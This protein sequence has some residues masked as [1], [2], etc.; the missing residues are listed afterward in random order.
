MELPRSMIATLPLVS[1]AQYVDGELGLVARIQHRGLA[2]S[3][4]SRSC[5]A[6]VDKQLESRNMSP[7]PESAALPPPFWPAL[8]P[9]LLMT[10]LPLSGALLPHAPARAA[11]DTAHQIPLPIELIDTEQGTTDDSAAR[12]YP[13]HHDSVAPLRPAHVPSALLEMLT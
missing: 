1:D 10:A 3:D 8:P 13:L 9:A 2:R 7:W 4:G 5:L 12:R 6:G 11:S